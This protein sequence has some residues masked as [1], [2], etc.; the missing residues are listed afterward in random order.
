MEPERH[1][2]RPDMPVHNGVAHTMCGKWPVDLSYISEIVED[3]DCVPCRLAWE[4]RK[5]M[6]KRGL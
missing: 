5:K 4:N 3:A 2:R 1:I 6:A